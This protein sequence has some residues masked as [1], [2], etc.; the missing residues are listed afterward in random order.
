MATTNFYSAGPKPLDFKG[1]VLYNGDVV[2]CVG[3][4]GQL[5]QGTVKSI[6]K[7]AGVS[8]T[9]PKGATRTINDWWNVEVEVVSP[10]KKL[11][12]SVM[13]SYPEKYIVKV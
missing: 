12:R 2:V 3:R 5:R 4:N 6:Q 9:D 11:R 8:Y 1:Q 7:K 13:F 10:V